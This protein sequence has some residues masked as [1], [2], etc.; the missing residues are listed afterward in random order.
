M[1]VNVD[2]TYV[3]CSRCGFVFGYPRGYTDIRCP[4][5]ECRHTRESFAQARYEE[6]RELRALVPRLRGVITRLKR[7]R[8]TDARRGVK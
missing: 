3:V 1:S 5:P 2:F 8:D 6:L 4:G 7:Q